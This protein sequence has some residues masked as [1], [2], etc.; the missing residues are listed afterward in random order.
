LTLLSFVLCPRSDSS[1]WTLQSLL[2]F[3][4][5]R[6]AINIGRCL[7]NLRQKNLASHFLH[8]PVEYLAEWIYTSLSLFFYSDGVGVYLT[9]LHWWHFTPTCLHTPSSWPRSDGMTRHHDHSLSVSHSFSIHRGRHAKILGWS[10]SLPPLPFPF[11]PQAPLYLSFPWLF[12]C[13]LFTPLPL[14][15]GPLN[16]A[17]HLILWGAL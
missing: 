3:N 8:H 1:F 16:T 5:L 9:I 4:I 10:K 7:T 2:H 14:E 13:P 15:V 11:C 17:T 12:P 6:P